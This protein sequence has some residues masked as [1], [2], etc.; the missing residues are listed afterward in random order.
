MPTFRSQVPLLTPLIGALLATAASTFGGELDRATSIEIDGIVYGAQADDRGPIGGGEGYREVVA[1]G[2]YEAHDLE[3]LQQALA[4]ATAGQT[5]F[6][7]GDVEIDLTALIYIEGLVLEVPE[8]VT[9]ASD[10]GHNQSPGGLLTSDALKTP[11]MIRVGPNVRIT[12]LRLRGPNTKR[13]LDHHRRA[14]KSKDGKT[15]GGGR[16]YYYKL[17]TSNGIVAHQSGLTVDNCEI[18]GFSH[19]G[20]DLRGGDNHQIHHNFI[21]HCQYQGLGY[22]VCHNKASSLIECNLF[23]WNRH[24]IAGTG[25]PGC[26]YTAHNNVE[27]GES[28]SHCFDM[29]GGRDRGDGTDIA[30]TRI[31]ITHNTFR[32]KQLPIKIRG[33]PEESCTVSGNWFLNHAGPRGAVSADKRTTIS[34][35]AYGNDPPTTNSD[36]DPP[37]ALPAN[38]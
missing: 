17:P 31:D 29:H 30:G 26:S 32:A 28:L 24:S 22:G 4:K 38:G 25:R 9:L 19:A 10:R 37:T 15:R 18:S 35:N 7:P 21:H 11:E 33:V 12:G 8:G 5:I 2:D 23:N 20:V 3:S 13:Y 36:G 16:E 6:I 27:L 34:G 1:T 14:F